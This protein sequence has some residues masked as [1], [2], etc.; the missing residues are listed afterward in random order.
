MKQILPHVKIGKDEGGRIFLVIDDYE[1]FDFID[2]FLNEKCDIS[3][4]CRKSIERIGGEIV[5]A[6]FP[7]S[8]NFSDIEENLMTLSSDEIEYIYRLNN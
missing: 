7:I 3:Y 6:Y 2:D 8:I 4:E 5:T 1:L